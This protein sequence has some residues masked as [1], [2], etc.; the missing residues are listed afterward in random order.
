M[1]PYRD[2]I[3]AVKAVKA[4]ATAHSRFSKYFN[5]P[6]LATP[7]LVLSLASGLLEL[8]VVVS[9]SFETL[10]VVG[11][12]VAGSGQMPPHSTQQT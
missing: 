5:Y 10:A 9:T 3:K 7:Y 11:M 4:T 12:T 8:S 6:D 1:L 2:V